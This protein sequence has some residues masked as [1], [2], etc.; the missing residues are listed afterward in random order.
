M[1]AGRIQPLK[2]PDVLLRAVEVMLAGGPVAAPAPRRTRR[3]RTLRLRPRAP[4]RAGR[5]RR[6]PRHQRRRTFRAAGDPER[7]RR[8]GVRRHGGGGAV[9][10]RVVRARRR[11]GA[12]DRYARRGGRRRRADD[13]GARRRQRAAG[14]HPRTARLGRRLR[15]LVDDPA[16]VERLGRGAV[17]HAQDF[18]W[19]RTAERTLEAYGAPPAGCV[20]RWPVKLG[21]R[22]HPH[23][24]RGERDRARGDL[25]EAS[26]AR[27]SR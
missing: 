14:R 9:L 19:E 3:R 23:L 2:A 16:L 10:Q 8:L 15:R 18:S 17:A 6:R 21:R 1:F 4:H 7:A 25:R 11:R 13:R 26:T 20:L 22:D 12:G 5:P 27:A 24:P